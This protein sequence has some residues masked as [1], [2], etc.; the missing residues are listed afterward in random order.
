MKTTRAVLVLVMKRSL[1]RNVP[2]GRAVCA[3]A[4]RVGAQNVGCAAEFFF[5]AFRRAAF[6]LP[7]IS[8]PNYRSNGYIYGAEGDPVAVPWDP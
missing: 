1:K 7:T 5:L 2:F 3:R 4:C 8:T 6:V